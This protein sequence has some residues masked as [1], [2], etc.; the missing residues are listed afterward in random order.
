MGNSHLSFCKFQPRTAISGSNFF[1]FAG[2]R[3]A[4]AARLRFARLGKDTARYRNSAK[5][6]EVSRL[7]APRL[8][9]APF[10]RFGAN[11]LKRAH[12]PRAADFSSNR[13]KFARVTPPAS[14]RDKVKF[15]VSFARI[16]SA[17]T[18]FK[19]TKIRA[20]IFTN[21]ARRFRLKANSGSAPE[22]TNLTGGCVCNAHG[23]IRISKTIKKNDG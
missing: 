5:R 7:D 3:S 22:K 23:R 18:P 1:N 16:K 2:A 14:R 10:P 12:F 9:S 17:K 19:N 8:K 4:G 13:R 6:A 20:A 15:S 21:G 11:S